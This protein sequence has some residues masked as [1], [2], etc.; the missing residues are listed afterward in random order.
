MANTCLPVV[1]DIL[2]GIMFI[3]PFT[4][5]FGSSEG[6]LFHAVGILLPLVSVLET[7]LLCAGC[8]FESVY[9]VSQMDIK[10][11]PSG[12]EWSDC[13]HGTYRSLL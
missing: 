1:V 8:T 4:N 7:V 12:I 11:L 9:I 2:L 3:Q 6:I 10:I 13:A 5:G